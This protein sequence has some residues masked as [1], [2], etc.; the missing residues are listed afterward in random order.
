M[1]FYQNPN[2]PVSQQPSPPCSRPGLEH[3]E[4][5]G[6]CSPRKRT[7]TGATHLNFCRC[8]S[9]T[10][11]YQTHGEIQTREVFIK[12]VYSKSNGAQLRVESSP[13]SQLSCLAAKFGIYYEDASLVAAMVAFCR[14]M[15]MTASRSGKPD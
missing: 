4:Y 6:C 10:K 2:L 8:I 1:S 12:L 14:P 15:A 5:S 13:V 9:S 3:F 11:Y 7:H